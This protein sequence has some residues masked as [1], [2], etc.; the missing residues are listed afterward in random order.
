TSRDNR[1]RLR[2]AAAREYQLLYSVREHAAVL[3]PQSYTE[4]APLGPTLLFEDFEGG[5]RLDRFLA[6]HPDLPFA[7]RIE[8]L[9]QLAHGLSYCHKR[10]VVHG[11]LSPEAVLVRERTDDEGKAKLEARMFNF[12]LGSGESISA[13]KHRS[14]LATDP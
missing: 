14:L 10:S 12:H 8:I 5:M 3:S 11:G 7:K 4:D 6:R 2:R 9:R 1:A 13:T